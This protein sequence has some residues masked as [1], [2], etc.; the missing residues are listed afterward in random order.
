M[1]T[2]TL[3]EPMFYLLAAMLLLPIAMAS[4]MWTG[5]FLDGGWTLLIGWWRF[6]ERVVPRITVEPIGML[7]GVV[8]VLAATI[9]LHYFVAWLYDAIRTKNDATIW[10]AEWSWRWTMCLIALVVLMF[11]AGLV[12]VGLQRTTVWL[13][14]TPEFLQRQSDL[15]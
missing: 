3:I 14:E 10:P 8:F 7:T 6:S 15:R 12:G 5:A 11:V 13:I 9:A 4:V 1:K 2:W